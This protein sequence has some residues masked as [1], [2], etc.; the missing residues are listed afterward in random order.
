MNCMVGECRFD[1]VPIEYAGNSITDLD[2]IAK[3]AVSGAE[4]RAYRL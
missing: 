1:F 2:T 4:A 3:A